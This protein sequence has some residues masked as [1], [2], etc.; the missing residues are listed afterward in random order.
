MPNP[1]RRK[2][3]WGYPVIFAGAPVIPKSLKPLSR[4]RRKDRKELLLQVEAPCMDS[5]QS[6]KILQRIDESKGAIIEFLQKLVSIP[7]VTGAEWEIQN[8]MAAKLKGMGL[9]VDMWEPNQE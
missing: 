9:K 2:S 1:L 5:K 8:F 4:L 3:K 7:S 6:G